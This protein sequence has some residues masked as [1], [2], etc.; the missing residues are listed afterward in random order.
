MRCLPCHE[1][2]ISTWPQEELVGLKY[3][4]DAGA[5]CEAHASEAVVR[6]KSMKKEP[7][8]YVLKQKETFVPS[9]IQKAERNWTE[10]EPNKGEL[11]E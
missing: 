4:L 7:S 1:N 2:K 6:L 10:R 11:I 9:V 3:L 8:K 5:L